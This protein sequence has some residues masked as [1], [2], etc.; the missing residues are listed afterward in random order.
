[1]RPVVP[2]NEVIDIDTDPT[3]MIGDGNDLGNELGQKGNPDP[4]PANIWDMLF[5]HPA[6]LAGRLIDAVCL[7]MSWHHCSELDVLNSR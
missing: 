7:D 1:M 5:S 2:D 6:I 3:E 4:D